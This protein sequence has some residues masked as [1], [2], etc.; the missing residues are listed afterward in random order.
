LKID[1]CYDCD[2]ESVVSLNGVNYC[3]AHFNERCDALQREAGQTKAQARA[4]IWTRLKCRLLG[5]VWHRLN[6]CENCG[7]DAYSMYFG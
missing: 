6:Y 1:L 2:S 4:T 3:Q 5:H 7:C